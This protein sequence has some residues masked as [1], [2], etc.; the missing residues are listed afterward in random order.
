MP[1]MTMTKEEKVLAYAVKDAR[2]PLSSVEGTFK[3][4]RR[5]FLC[6][7]D[8]VDEK[9]TS[10]GFNMTPI[11]MLVSPADFKDIKDHKGDGLGESKPD[12]VIAKG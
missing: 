12:I 7:M 9:D 1:R 6:L 10:R 11:A 8:Y 3:G 2:F 4:E 5:V